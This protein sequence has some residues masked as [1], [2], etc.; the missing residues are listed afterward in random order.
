MS[1]K[2]DQRKSRWCGNLKGMSGLGR[3]ERIL[4]CCDVR[5]SELFRRN[6]NVK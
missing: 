4:V 3:G 5:I 6:F 1:R 2:F